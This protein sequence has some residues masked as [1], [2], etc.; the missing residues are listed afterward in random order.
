LGLGVSF[1]VQDYSDNAK[2]FIENNH[3]NVAK[4]TLWAREI[5]PL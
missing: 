1:G 2:P 3:F 4:V 5:V